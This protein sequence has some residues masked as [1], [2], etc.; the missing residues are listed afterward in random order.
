[1][2]DTTYEYHCDGSLFGIKEDEFVYPISTNIYHVKTVLS[3]NLEIKILYYQARNTVIFPPICSNCG[4][5]NE[6]V[7]ENVIS[8]ETSNKRAKPLY[9]K[10]HREGE[11][12]VIFGRK[13]TK[14]MKRREC[15]SN[16]AYLTVYGHKQTKMTDNFH[17]KKSNLT[18]LIMLP[19]TSQGCKSVG[20]YIPKNNSEEDE[21]KEISNIIN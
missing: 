18:P 21:K 13:Q 6:F 19:V 11:K 9:I 20:E 10:C 17:I 3:C 14:K 12:L 15:G 5:N 8:Q 1:M 16:Y 7:D 2:E 4:M